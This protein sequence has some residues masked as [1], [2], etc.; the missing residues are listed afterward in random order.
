MPV[1]RC[2]LLLDAARRQQS[3]DRSSQPETA[4]RSRAEIDQAKGIIM[5]VHGCGADEAFPKLV[6]RSQHRNV[7]LNRLDSIRR[8]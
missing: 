8:K 1:C 7:E 5:A 2:L 4:L 3:R 6:K